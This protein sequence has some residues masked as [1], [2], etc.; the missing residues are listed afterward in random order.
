MKTSQNNQDEVQNIIPIFLICSTMAS[1]TVSDLRE[2]S[3]QSIFF[4][5]DVLYDT[6]DLQSMIRKSQNS[7]K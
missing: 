3:L 2:R 1:S 6:Y 5:S 4:V 7:K